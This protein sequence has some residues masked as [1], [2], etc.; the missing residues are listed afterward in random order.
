MGPGLFPFCSR[1]SSPQAVRQAALPRCSRIYAW[2]PGGRVPSAFL[3]ELFGLL[4]ES[5]AGANAARCGEL[6]IV[7]GRHAMGFSRRTA[8]SFMFYGPAS[9][10]R[11]RAYHFQ[12]LFWCPAYRGQCSWRNLTRAAGRPAIFSCGGLCWK[13]RIYIGGSSTI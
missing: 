5:R 8:L 7:F 12:V 1:G 9:V 13:G 6:I 2:G 10:F 4:V 3:F 11:H